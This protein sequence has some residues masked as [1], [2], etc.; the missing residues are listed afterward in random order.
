MV[1]D[2]VLNPADR[3]GGAVVDGAQMVDDAL[4]NVFVSSAQTHPFFRRFR[5]RSY[6]IRRRTWRAVDLVQEFG[7]HE[8][9]VIVQTRPLLFFV[10]KECFDNLTVG[11]RDRRL[12]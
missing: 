12:E 7:Q 3:H 10:G 1:G 11:L 6:E 5:I 4:A 8:M 9:P 2:H